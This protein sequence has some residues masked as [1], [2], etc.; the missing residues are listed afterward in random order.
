MH[1]K[2]VYMAQYK[3]LRE[4]TLTFDGNSFVDVFVGKN[5][6]GKSNL[7]EALIEIFRHIVEFDLEK[8][9]LVFNYRLNYEIDGRQE[10]PKTGCSDHGVDKSE[11]I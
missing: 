2:S 1:L 5:A 10:F 9:E 3:N 6:T 4:F 11:H 7:F 8:A